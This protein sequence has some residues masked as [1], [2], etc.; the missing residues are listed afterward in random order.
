MRTRS[1]ALAATVLSVAWCETGR[2]DDA[3]DKKELEKKLAEMQK[4][5]DE[6]SKKLNDGSNR[7]EDELEQRVAEL[8]KVTK[9]D[10]DGLFAY[11]KN[12]LKLD[13]VDGAFKLSI[14]GRIQDDYTAWDNDDDNQNALG[15]TNSSAEFRRARIGLSGTIYKN[16]EYKAEWDFA[17]QA[18]GSAAYTDVFM[19]LNNLGGL[20]M[21]I[22]VGH[23]DEP[24]GLDHLTSSKYTTFTER[25]FLETYVPAR[26]N[27][28]M[29]FGGLLDN[30]MAWFVGGFKDTDPYGN[31]VTPAR[32]GEH[33]VTAR[34]TGRPYLSEDGLTWIHIGASVSRRNPNAETIQLRTRPE[35]H[36]GPRFVDTG[37]L[38][39]IDRNNMIGLEAAANVKSLHA[40]AEVLQSDLTGA[41]TQQDF[42]SEAA[43]VQVGYF[44]TGDNRKYDVPMARW[45]RLNVKK[46]YG[47]DGWG[48]WEVAV[49]WS[50]IDL[51]DGDI[52]GGKMTDLTFGINWYLNPNTKVMLDWVHF[53]P[54]RQVTTAGT[55]YDLTSSDAFVMSFRIDF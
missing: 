12:G 7:S 39:G 44:L 17:D 11:W 22:R 25:S 1:I 51:N 54:T 47:A 10:Q 29:L 14:F 48:A 19:Q 8:E 16:V 27:G 42:T 40:Q 53:D 43:S 49:R 35:V 20:P 36:V 30:R 52:R 23:F 6:M 41:G 18:N 21:N 2:A 13:S 15:K 3:A 34:L 33:A 46:N 32:P 31:R 37:V 50:H 26:N 24:M 45:D 28:I 55:T 4:Q 38:T 9:K 5:I